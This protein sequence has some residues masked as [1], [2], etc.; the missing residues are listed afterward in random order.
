MI[1]KKAINKSTVLLSIF[2]FIVLISLLGV[3]LQIFSK[4][5]LSLRW[6]QVIPDKIN[7]QSVSY[8][9]DFVGVGTDTGFC[10]VFDSSGK[11]VFEKKFPSPILTL[12]FSYNSHFL[13]V[14][15][16]SLL[17][18]DLTSGK[19]VWE[20]FKKDYV[21]EDFWVFRETNGESRCGVFMRSKKD[22]TLIYQ[23]LDKQG[24]T[25]KEFTLPEVF[26][27]YSLATSGNGKYLLLSL[28]EGDIYLFQ[29]DGIAVWN[30]HLDPPVKEVSSD[31]PSYPIF[32]TVMNDGSV[33]LAYPAEEYGK[34]LYVSELINNKANTVWKNILPS[35]ITGL[36]LSPDEKKVLISSQ[37]KL[38]VFEIS[39]KT[40]YSLDQFGYK[41]SVTS[42]GTTNVLVG[43]LPTEESNRRDD[44]ALVFK[45][46]SLNRK[47]V[48][49]QKRS[50]KDVIDFSM[51]KNGYVFV[52]TSFHRV[53][54]YRYVLQ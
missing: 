45:L 23:Y 7:C 4:R 29:S 11:K 5:D 54:F 44:N 39:G 12:K 34:D 24:M 43:F 36:V 50:Q 32:Q 13:Y 47:H 35:P 38:I 15:S 40:L 21:V 1:K 14:K 3:V 19:V 6:T 16:Y 10:Y 9:G 52:E 51:T 41:P 49:W 25:V 33:C 42:L 2:A 17:A 26:G 28:Q 20:K 22:I 27:N 30:I 37:N 48:L 8:S 18:V 46:I 53:S 31:F